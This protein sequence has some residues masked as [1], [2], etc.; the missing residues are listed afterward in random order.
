MSPIC[1]VRLRHIRRLAVDADAARERVRDELYDARELQR[2]LQLHEPSSKASKHHH[3]AP[4]PATSHVQVTAR[5][6]D[7]REAL[8]A[9][10]QKASQANTLWVACREY[11]RQ[12]GI[13][14]NTFHQEPS[15]HDQ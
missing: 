2:R 8:N 12:N 3:E 9:A 10:S 15:A 14:V 1:P 6:N 5:L 11:A 4:P 13:D 7:L